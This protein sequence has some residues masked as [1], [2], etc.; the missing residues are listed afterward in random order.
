MLRD[1]IRT[2][3]NGY[4]GRINRVAV[5]DSRGEISGGGMHDLG[6]A[7]DVLN[8]ENKAQGV[9]IALRTMFPD[10]IAFDEIGNTDEL[11]AVSQ[12]FSAGV[13]IVTTAHIDSLFDLETREITKKLTQSGAID[14][15]AVL[16]RITGGKITVTT[17]KELYAK[18]V[19]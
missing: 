10:V 16:P 6:L 7:T 2:L 5:I 19:V 15:I 18:A 17:P 13:K 4:N 3:S 8:A 12:C 11:K 14:Q 1:F 9:E